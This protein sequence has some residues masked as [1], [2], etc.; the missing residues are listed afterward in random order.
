MDTQSAGGYFFPKAYRRW[1]KH[2]RCWLACIIA[3]TVGGSALS[4]SAQTPYPTSSAITAT[5]LDATKR[6][7][8]STLLTAPPAAPIRKK[9]TAELCPPSIAPALV[10]DPSAKQALTIVENSVATEILFERPSKAGETAPSR[11]SFLVEFSPTR[12]LL[13]HLNPR[14]Q[15][16]ASGYSAPFLFDRTRVVWMEGKLGTDVL[17]FIPAVRDCGVQAVVLCP[18][19]YVPHNSLVAS[20]FTP[21]AVRELISARADG[22]F[23][24]PAGVPGKVQATLLATN[25]IALPEKWFATAMGNDHP[26]TVV[27]Y[28]LPRENREKYPP[29][30]TTSLPWLAAI[31]S[32]LDFGRENESLR[33]SMKRLNV[34]ISN[35]TIPSYAQL[36]VGHSEFSV[37]GGDCYLV[38]EWTETKL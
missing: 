20:H 37:E 5:P 27:K 1:R 34:E 32:R 29:F 18:R 9:T 16:E 10:A 7:L 17:V 8:L 33:T 2:L 23:S 3:T 15:S 36:T 13:Q 25:N 19:S 21:I 24:P 31:E 12:V 11:F 4:A 6:N 28:Q 30:T 38:A 35:Y 26:A 14:Y 22:L